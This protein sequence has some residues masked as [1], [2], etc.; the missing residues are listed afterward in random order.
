MALLPIILFVTTQEAEVWVAVLR[1]TI[2][3]T[4]NS[5]NPL[6]DALLYKE[7]LLIEKMKGAEVRLQ[8][9]VPKRQ[10]ILRLA[11]KESMDEF[12]NT[13]T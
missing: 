3:I 8:V 11:S 6:Y 9:I 13:A 2:S 12:C 1:T 4:L 10:F 5:V 7:N